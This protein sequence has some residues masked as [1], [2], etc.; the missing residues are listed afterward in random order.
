MF[1][2]NTIYVHIE[3]VLFKN[4]K[5]ENSVYKDDLETFFK[6]YNFFFNNEAYFNKFF[7]KFN[8]GFNSNF[9]YLYF[10]YYL[11][12]KNNL[13]KSGD[14]TFFFCMVFF[15]NKSFSLKTFKSYNLLDFFSKS[16]N[17]SVYVNNNLK[18]NLNNKKNLFNIKL[19][20]VENNYKV[21][22]V[23]QFLNKTANIIK[24]S[25]VKFSST[26]IVKYINNNTDYSVYFLRKNKSFNKGR[27]SRNR[28]NYRTGV[29]W[30][31]YINVIALFGLYYAFYRF[32]FNFGYLWWLFYCLPASFIVPSAIRHRL[33]NPR[34]LYNSICEYFNFL[35]SITNVIFFNKK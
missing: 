3:S 34:V 12:K 11:S 33:Y 22:N 7:K 10:L 20:K 16:Q 29:Y 27:Y 5:T 23:L 4:T 26:S 35:Y 8:L 2:L 6:F 17:L 30:C 18:K 24:S 19:N 15:L 25:I 9:L 32:T 28:Q 13:I 21:V 1:L 14:F 31:L